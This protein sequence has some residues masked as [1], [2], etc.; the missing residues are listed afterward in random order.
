MSDP[1]DLAAFLKEAWDHLRNGVADAQAPARLLS[2]AT[3]SPD[4]RP[5]VR[6]VALR[7]VDPVQAVLEVHTDLVTPK[8]ASLRSTPIAALHAWIAPAEVQIR[9][10]ARVDILSGDAVESQWVAVP[11]ASRVSYGTIPDPGQPIDAAFEYD[12]PADR[13]RFAVLRCA[14]TE[15]DLVHL[16]PRHHRAIYVSQDDWRGSWVAP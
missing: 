6:T 8:V 4:G 10:S 13:N 5:E 7:A 3:V 14:L 16:G 9:A 11:S 2:F 15:I 12:K 1:N